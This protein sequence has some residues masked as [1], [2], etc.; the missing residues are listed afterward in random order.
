MNISGPN[1]TSP[2]KN[3]RTGLFLIDKSEVIFE[4]V[5]AILYTEIAEEAFV[6]IFHPTERPLALTFCPGS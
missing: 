3:D 4:Q 1:M 5:H 6:G 2:S